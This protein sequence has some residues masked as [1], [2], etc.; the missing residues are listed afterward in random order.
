ALLLSSIH[1]QYD[2]QLAKSPND[3]AFVTELDLISDLNQVILPRVLEAAKGLEN[4][5]SI[6]KSTFDKIKDIHLASA[7]PT[8]ELIQNLLLASDRNVKVTQSISC[9]SV[10]DK[11]K[12]TLDPVPI[13]VT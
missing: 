13:S 9:V 5:T 11:T 8:N 7:P 6:V 2:A 1:K 4:Q 12:V 10:L 3:L